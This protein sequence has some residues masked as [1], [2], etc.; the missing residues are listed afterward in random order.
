[1]AV[2]NYQVRLHHVPETLEAL[3]RTHKIFNDRLREIL[4]LLFRMR[5][6]ECGE[7]PE[8]QALYREIALFITGCPSNNAPY[9]LNSVC[10]KNWVPTTA[11]KIKATISDPNGELIEVT[12]ETWAE[13]AAQLSAHGDLLFDKRES[14]AISRQQW[15]R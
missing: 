1:M 3:W 9:L 8:D 10:I 14:W 5:R 4:A 11:R 15:H 12:G 7:S 6:G 13:R 2:K